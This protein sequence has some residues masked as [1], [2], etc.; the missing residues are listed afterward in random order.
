MLDNRELER[1]EALLGEFNP[2]VALNWTRQELRHSAFLRWLLDPSET[3]GLGSYFL[4]LFLKRAASQTEGLG[5]TFPSVIELDSWDYS[6]AQVVQEW[7]NIDVLIHDESIPFVGVIETKID[8]AEH[9]SQLSRYRSIV[10][11][12]FPAAKKLFVFL[13]I[14]G[15][16]PSDDNYV[17]LS[18]A[19]IASLI[20]DV[21]TRREDQLSTEVRSFLQ[22]YA[23]MLWRH[24][25]E[26]SEI[27]EI[28][29]QIYKTHKRA[30]DVIFEHRPDR[31]LQ[32]SEFLQQLIA[33]SSELHAD[34]CSKA[35]VRFIPAALDFIP[36][37]G[38]GWTRSKRLVL[39]ELDQ[40]AG[41][42]TL[43]LIIGPGDDRS[44]AAVREEV[45]R[46]ES[47][48][49]RATTKFYPKYWTFHMERWTTKKQYEE[50]EI[51]ELQERLRARF[52]RFCKEDMPRVLE[53]LEQLEHHEWKE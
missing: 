36:R 13:T 18:Y 34:H 33:E 25:V 12:N 26:D 51:A 9:S 41:S 47:V 3:H 23:E 24:I 7:N 42:V 6:S 45:V 20:D 19:E 11:E 27:Q 43:K 29:R 10:A 32:V 50:S 52:D 8:T 17:S 4:R 2:F 49:N 14:G 30:L 48:F 39:F 31:A 38:D 53:G 37:H 22:H 15:D 35:Y 28:C 46:N 5:G 1:L 21:T 44:R 40:S 16:P